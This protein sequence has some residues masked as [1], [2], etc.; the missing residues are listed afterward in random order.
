MFEWIFTDPFSVLE[1]LSINLSYKEVRV[2]IQKLS[3]DFCVKRVC[4]GVPG[5]AVRGSDPVRFGFVRSEFNF[6][7]FTRVDLASVYVPQSV[8]CLIEV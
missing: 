8:F 7:N 3:S 5:E 1:T 6:F 4:V 2:T